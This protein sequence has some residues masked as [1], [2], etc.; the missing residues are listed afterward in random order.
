MEVAS[1]DFVVTQPDRPRGRGKRLEAPPVKIAASE[2]GLDVRQPVHHAE[3]SQIFRGSGL[4]VAVVVAYGRILKRDVLDSVKHGFVNVHFSLLPRWRGA[5]PVE[6]A[7]L[8]GDEYSGVSLMVLDEGMDTGPVF[9]AVETEIAEFETAGELTGR[10]ASLGADVLRDHLEDYIHEKLLPARQMQTGATTAPRLTTAEARLDWRMGIDDF[11]RAVRAFNPRPGG[12][13][14]GEGTRLKI[15]EVGPASPHVAAGD[16]KIVDGRPILGL[17]N[18]AVELVQVQQAGKPRLSG[19][20]WA[21]GRRGFGL[22]L[23]PAE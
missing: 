16:I 5:A 6:R 18:G 14:E 15:F 20:E 13:A 17:G 8:A 12:W 4:D 9:A 10:L 3:L 19:R 1:V 11:T 21:N 23:D 2:W 22:R 7:V